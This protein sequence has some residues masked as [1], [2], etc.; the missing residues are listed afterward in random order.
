MTDNVNHAA[1]L[2]K[3]LQEAH[4]KLHHDLMVHEAEIN[5]RMAAA[6]PLPPPPAFASHPG[7]TYIPVPEPVIVGQTV[8]GV[9]G[10]VVADVAGGVGGVVH[11]V[12]EVGADVVGGVGTAIDV[13][14]NGIDN[15]FHSVRVSLGL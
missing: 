8:G 11:G 1:E 9:V 13:V 12:G 6:A 14:H 4:D 3:H 15:F 7:V 2:A 10:G 5:A